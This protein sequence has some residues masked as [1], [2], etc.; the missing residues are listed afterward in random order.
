MQFYKIIGNLFPKFFFF[1]LLEAAC[2]YSSYIPGFLLSLCF[3]VS[4]R[5]HHQK[6]QSIN[7][8]LLF[9]KVHNMRVEGEDFGAR[10]LHIAMKIRL[11]NTYNMFRLVPWT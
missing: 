11:F 1:T 4:N 3:K 9:K 2:K 6:Q 7:S 5:P 10:L 8:S